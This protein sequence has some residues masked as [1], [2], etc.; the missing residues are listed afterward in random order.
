MDTH[1]P[2]PCM[3]GLV[4]MQGSLDQPPIVLRTSVLKAGLLMIGSGIAAFFCGSLIT[5]T[6]PPSRAL[7][8]LVAFGLAA[9][10]FAWRLVCPNILTLSPEGLAWQ[11][12]FRTTRWAWRDVSRFRAIQVHIFSQ[13]VGFDVADGVPGP[14]SFTQYYVRY[15]GAD[16]SLGGSWEVSARALAEI[17]NAAQARWADGP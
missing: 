16:N 8:G 2:T 7:S 9:V 17:L 1:P 6:P 12:P 15:A 3:R 10:Y 13:H 5:M 11:S 14:M 4:I